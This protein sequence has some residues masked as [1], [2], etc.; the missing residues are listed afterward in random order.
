MPFGAAQSV[1]H[2]APANA[3]PAGTASTLCCAW[4]QRNP[5]KCNPSSPPR[6]QSAAVQRGSLDGVPLD[7]ELCALGDAESRGFLP[8]SPPV[9]SRAAKRR[10]E[11]RPARFNPRKSNPSLTRRPRRLFRR[12]PVPAR[13]FVFHPCRF[14]PLFTW[15][16]SHTHT[17]SYPPRGDMPPLSLCAIAA[18][19]PVHTASNIG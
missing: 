19:A 15:L 18:A 10:S 6:Q 8:S 1:P 2:W 3:P 17:A 12:F 16:F 14:A 4:R 9:S 13:L 11:R 5:L 7:S